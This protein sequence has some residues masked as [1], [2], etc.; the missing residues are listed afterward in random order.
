MAQHVVSE[1]FEGAT[2]ECFIHIGRLGVQIS[3]DEDGMGEDERAFTW[4]EMA[5]PEILVKAFY[6]VRVGIFVQLCKLLADVYQKRAMY[7]EITW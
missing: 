3:W 5:D 4:E 6:G 2:D 1:K 7:Q